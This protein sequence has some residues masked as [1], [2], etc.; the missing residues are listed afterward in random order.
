MMVSPAS[1]SEACNVPT[2]P[3][4]FSLIEPPLAKVTDPGAS[5]T[6]LMVTVRVVSVLRPPFT[7]SCAVITTVVD[8]LAS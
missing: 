6:L 8:W 5:L 3:V 2:G 4:E 7:R 1:G